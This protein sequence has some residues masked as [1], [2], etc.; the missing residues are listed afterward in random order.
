MKRPEG[1]DHF[2]CDGQSTLH[3]LAPAAPQ[4]GA[5]SPPLTF[6]AALD[7]HFD[8]VAGRVFGQR[9]NSVHPVGEFLV[10]EQT[11]TS[12]VLMPLFRPGCLCVLRRLGNRAPAAA[13][14]LCPDR[15]RRRGRCRRTCSWGGRRGWRVEQDFRH[16]RGSLFGNGRVDFPKCR[17]GGGSR[18]VPVPEE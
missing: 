2:I 3:L 16:Q 12:P 8:F 5:I 7:F 18:V 17:W 1:Q 14:P 9:R 15:R 4:A 11:I 13:S 10:G 6:L